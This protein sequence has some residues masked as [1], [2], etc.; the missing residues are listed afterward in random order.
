MLKLRL[1]RFQALSQR[2]L[3]RDDGRQSHRPRLLTNVPLPNLAHV[4]EQAQRH[5]AI[6]GALVLEEQVKEERAILVGSVGAFAPWDLVEE[7]GFRLPELLVD[8]RTA[9]K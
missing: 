6:S 8:K 1:M 7:I 9:E 5:P 2:Q 4:S 3:P